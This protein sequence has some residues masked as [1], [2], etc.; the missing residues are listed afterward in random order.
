MNVDFNSC[1]HDWCL[2]KGPN[3]QYTRCKTVSKDG[4]TCYNPTIR[5]GST[6]GGHPA[7]HKLNDI[8]DWCRQLFPTSIKGIA[9]Y[10]TKLTFVTGA[11]FWCSRYHKT[12]DEKN[13]HWCDWLDGYWKDSALNSP[14][15]W[16]Y[17][18]ME[19]V[20]CLIP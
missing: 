10:D 18:L 17:H 20:T 5:Y 19:S 16:R 3:Q 9:T 1:I 2:Q 7:K 13:A 11:V 6:I 12:F 4:R 14:G 8:D 15:H